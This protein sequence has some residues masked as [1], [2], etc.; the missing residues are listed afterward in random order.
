MSHELK[1]KLSDNLKSL[2]SPLASFDAIKA[3]AKLYQNIRKF[4]DMKQVIEVETPLLGFTSVTSPYISSL[5]VSDNKQ[6]YY[7]QTSPEY[8]MK[9]F[10][11]AYSKNSIFQICKSFRKEEIGRQ[12]HIEFSML[13]WYRLD[14]SIFDLMN[15]TQ[16]LLKLVLNKD[17]NIK[18]Y[19]Y[20]NIFLKYLSIDPLEISYDYLLAR[21]KEL[22]KLQNNNLYQQLTFDDMLQQLFCKYIEPKLKSVY[23]YNFPKSQAALAKINQEDSRVANRFELYLNGIE[24]ANGYD[25]LLDYSS[26]KNRFDLENQERQQ[27]NL[28][29]INL[30]YLLLDALK[31]SKGLPSCSGVALGLD[32]LLMFL[33]NEDNIEKVISFRQ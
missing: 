5:E 21:F 4:F 9:R 3:R 13:E 6:K 33:L 7:L 16:E 24:L 25:E 32:R 26:Y 10:L 27:Q 18:K 30:D 31:E 28:P 22:I 2:W 20:Q 29:T 14:F 15:E 11:C 8:A 19:T 1:N 12:H 23:I 17:L